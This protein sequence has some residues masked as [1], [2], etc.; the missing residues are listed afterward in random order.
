MT[1]AQLL[2][3]LASFDPQARIIIASPEGTTFHELK[4]VG[5]EDPAEAVLW[6][7]GDALVEE[8]DED[9]IPPGTLPH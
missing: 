9:E 7:E 4:E 3:I 2:E 6:P 1:A 8:G 5:T